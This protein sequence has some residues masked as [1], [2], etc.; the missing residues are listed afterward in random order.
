[1]PSSPQRVVHLVKESRP[2]LSNG[3]TSAQPLQLPR[4]EGRRPRPRRRHRARVPARRRGRRRPARRCS[5]DG[6]RH[7][8]LDIGPA[9]VKAMPLDRYLAALRRPG[10]RAGAGHPARRSSTPSSGRRGYETA[11]VALAIKDRTGI[12]VVYEVRS[13]FEANWTDEVRYE[14]ER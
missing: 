11:L 10:A 5:L 4:R 7:Y 3:F 13:F 9:D 6:I 1:M 14:D 8:H 2:Y 12:P